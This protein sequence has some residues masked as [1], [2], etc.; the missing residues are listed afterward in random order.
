MTFLLNAHAQNIETT[1]ICVIGT[2]HNDTDYFNSQILDS[3]LNRIEPDLIL[4]ELDSSFFTSDFQYDTIKRPY[5]LKKEQSSPTIIATNNYRSENSC[6]VRPYDISGRND[7]L[8]AHNYFELKNKMY[9]DI[10]KFGAKGIYS[11]RSDRDLSTLSAGLSYINSLKINS[12]QE[13]NSESVCKLIDL[14][15]TIYLINALNIVESND[16][17]TKYKSFAQFQ[18]DFWFLRNAIMVENIS[19][20]ILHYKRIV[21]LTGNMHKQLLVSGLKRKQENIKIKEFWEY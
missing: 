10:F 3:I 9:F 21:V 13:I 4:V 12:L 18:L 11:S 16:S 17:L 7:S 20:F 19:Q 5:L 1:E 8:R 2:L 6:D 15:Q 14:Q